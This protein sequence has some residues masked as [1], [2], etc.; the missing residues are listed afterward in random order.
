MGIEAT[1]VLKVSPPA[2]GRRCRDRRLLDN[3][4]SGRTTGRRPSQ[5]ATNESGSG[6]AQDKTS[7]VHPVGPRLLSLHE[8]AVYLGCSERTVRDLILDGVIP[9]V[10]LTSRIQVDILDLD[11]LIES[12]KK[13]YE[14]QN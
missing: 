2:R 13:I 3:P 6:S 5:L 4:D 1:E 8:A 10:E 12:K 11:K 9:Q 14:Y 7:R